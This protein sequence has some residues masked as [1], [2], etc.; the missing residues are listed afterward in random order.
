MQAF[1]LDDGPDAV[2]PASLL[3]AHDVHYRA[4]PTDP[5]AY[6]GPLDT[7]KAAR[8]YV[9]QDLVTLAPD[10]PGL[11]AMEQKFVGEHH[12]SDDEVRFVLEGDGIFDIRADD[13][14]WMRVVVEPGD[15]IVVPAGRHHRFLLTER[16]AIRCVRLFQDA[17][18]WVPHDR[19]VP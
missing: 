12:H 6:Q 14:R 1:W 7:L 13:D 9:A 10:T 17:A 15:L 18:G 16:K 2:I 3:E 8:G 4:L 19:E 5:A 11:A